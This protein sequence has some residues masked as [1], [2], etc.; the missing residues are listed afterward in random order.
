MLGESVVGIYK[1]VED[2]IEALK[3]GSLADGVKAL[4]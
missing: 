3:N 4:V 1:M 2:I